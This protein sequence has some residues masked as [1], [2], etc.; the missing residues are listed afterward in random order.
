M[1]NQFLPITHKITIFPFIK[2]LN[3]K[4]ISTYQRIHSSFTPS[5][6]MLLMVRSTTRCIITSWNPIATLFRGEA[7]ACKGVEKEDLIHCW[8]NALCMHLCIPRIAILVHWWIMSGRFFFTLTDFV[9]FT[10]D[11]LFARC[12]TMVTYQ[13]LGGWLLSYL[14][15][16]WIDGCCI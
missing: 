10:R 4:S 5:S 6:P 12:A 16:S 13:V 9:H 14:N 8:L 11:H 2:V 7:Y 15:G 3:R 1:H